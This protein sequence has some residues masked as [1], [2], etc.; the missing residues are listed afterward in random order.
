MLQEDRV[1][2]VLARL[3]GV[4]CLKL[5][6]RL[7]Q[8]LVLVIDN[9]SAFYSLHDHMVKCAGTIQPDF[10][11]HRSIPQPLRTR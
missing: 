3:D 4:L 8:H 6:I 9:P 2:E 11:W 10:P 5:L 1:R 7:T